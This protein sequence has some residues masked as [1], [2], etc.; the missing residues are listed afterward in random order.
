[1]PRTPPY[2]L[3]IL[4][5]HFEELQ[6]LWELR[7]TAIRD[8][9]YLITDVAELDER[10]EAHTDGLVLG[11]EHSLPLLEEGLAGDESAVAFS[12]TYVLLRL[13]SETAARQVMEAFLAAEGEA[14]G[15]IARALCH[16][17]IHVLEGQLH[18]ALGSA[19]D[20]VAAAA[21][22]VLAFHRKLS[23]QPDRISEL[24]RGDDPQVR[25]TAW[26]VV[27]LIG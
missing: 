21:A 13:Q 27:A 6:M 5:E 11:G 8:P 3:S 12:A 25:R 14:L 20:P 7:Q 1:M 17:P 18:E 4:E 23:R 2:L 19:P 10:I 22:E 26:R 24:L 16:G 9:D 15:G